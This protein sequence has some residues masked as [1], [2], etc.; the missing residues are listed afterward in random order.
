[1]EWPSHKTHSGDHVLT[2]VNS[3][4]IRVVKTMQGNESY[5]ISNI[6]DYEDLVDLESHTY[7]SSGINELVNIRMLSLNP[8]EKPDL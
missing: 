1:M 4:N 8:E 6:D 5:Y 3:G 7:T 2:L